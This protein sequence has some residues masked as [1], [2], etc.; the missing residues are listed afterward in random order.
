M[1]INYL[2]EQNRYFGALLQLQIM[3]MYLCSKALKKIYNL[4]S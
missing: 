3:F 4:F 2:V 1:S